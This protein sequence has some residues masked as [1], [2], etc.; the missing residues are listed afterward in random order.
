MNAY[1]VQSDDIQKLLLVP[2][3]VGQNKYL[4]DMRHPDVVVS[5]VTSYD[6]INIREVHSSPASIGLTCVQFL[7]N[8]EADIAYR[9]WPKSV[10][11]VLRP[12]FPGML[13]QI[14]KNLFT[15]VSCHVCSLTVAHS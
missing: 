8:L 3:Q 1:L 7:N 15:F 13:R 10:S 6:I 5:H 2:V 14:A 11:E 9:R 12:T 4:I